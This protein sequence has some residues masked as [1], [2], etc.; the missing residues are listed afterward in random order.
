MAMKLTIDEFLSNNANISFFTEEDASLFYKLIA[1]N[2]YPTAMRILIPYFKNIGWSSINLALGYITMPYNQNYKSLL[3]SSLD[4]FVLNLNT[5]SGIEHFYGN[6]L[7]NDLFK[8]NEHGEVELNKCENFLLTIGFKAGNS[9]RVFLDSVNNDL[10]SNINGDSI[11]YSARIMIY[12]SFIKQCIGTEVALVQTRIQ[13]EYIRLKNKFKLSIEFMNNI[14]YTKDTPTI[15]R[16]SMYSILNLNLYQ[17]FI[18]S[19]SNKN[20]LSSVFTLLDIVE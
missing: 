18:A 10:N 8:I 3:D 20:F 7:I 13:S 12:Y 1:N 11:D 16:L 14:L 2:D 9:K 6:Y 19:H 4:D 17:Q 15:S 5:I